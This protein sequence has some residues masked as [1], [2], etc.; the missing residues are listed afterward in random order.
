MTLYMNLETCS[1]PLGFVSIQKLPFSFHPLDLKYHCDLVLNAIYNLIK[2]HEDQANIVEFT[3]L[4]IL[5]V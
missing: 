4:E 3:E 1:S 2:F 5:D